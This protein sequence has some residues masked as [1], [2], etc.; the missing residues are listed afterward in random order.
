MKIVER[1]RGGCR[2]KARERGRTRE[3]KGNI[4]RER[5]ERERDAIEA[6]Y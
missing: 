2:N 5:G 1:E 4:A 6:L 3:E